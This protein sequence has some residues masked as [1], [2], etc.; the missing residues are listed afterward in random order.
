MATSDANV[1]IGHVTLVVHDLPA[2]GA[3]YESV[4][5]LE[6]IS[7]DATEARY[8]VDGKVLVILKADASARKSSRS[9]AGLFHTAFLL[10][11]RADL[12][13]WLTRAAETGI[14]LDGASDHLV[15][16]AVYL[17]DPEGSGIE[18]YR[19]RAREDWPRKDGMIAMVTDPIDLRDVMVEA[20]GPW[21]G[22][23]KGT[24][25]GHVH[26]Q[27]GALDPAEPFYAET[28]GAD[29]MARY[30]GA[31]FH[32]WG[33]YHHHL[34]TNV[35]NSRGAKERHQPATGLVEVG[36]KAHAEPLAAFREAY[37]DSVADPWGTRFT[38]SAK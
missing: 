19:D 22:A 27:V 29:V 9:E 1:E 4:L 3:F 38:W 7:G 34:A 26:L 12:G 8:G 36:L 32:G 23:P 5:G 25:I 6:R 37:G 16:E 17:H 10:P 21:R 15:S 31:N 35:W 18:I 30:P 2:V 13:A 33:G 11:E 20:R 24:V 28:L 14:R